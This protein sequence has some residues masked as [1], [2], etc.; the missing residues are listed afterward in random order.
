M[1][2]MIRTR[3][4]AFF[5]EDD[6][7]YEWMIK[8][9]TSLLHN[10]VDIVGIIHDAEDIIGIIHDVEDIVGIVKDTEDLRGTIGKGTK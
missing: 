8:A 10:I 4:Q 2:D 9:F 3:K 5:A 7:G 6:V 1:S